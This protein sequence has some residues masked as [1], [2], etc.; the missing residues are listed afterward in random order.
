[1]K[2][3]IVITLAFAFLAMASSAFAAGTT[4]GPGSSNTTAIAG[5][6]FIP[7]TSVQVN[8]NANN[9]NYCVTSLHNSSLAQAA[10]KQWAA[11]NTDSTIKYILNPATFA[12]CTGPQAMPSGTWL[13]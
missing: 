7:S 11:L 12:A 3:Y 2:K 1:M 8:A 9:T 5:A 10:G 13:Q 6:N 4:F